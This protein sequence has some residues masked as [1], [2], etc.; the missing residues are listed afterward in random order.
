MVAKRL[1]V[2]L[3]F[4]AAA[5]EQQ[6]AAEASEDQSRTAKSRR[7]SSYE[8]GFRGSKDWA[9]SMPLGAGASQTAPQNKFKY[10]WAQRLQN[11]LNYA[12]SHMNFWWR[13]VQ[14]EKMQ[15]QAYLDG[16][17]R[18]KELKLP[19]FKN[20]HGVVVGHIDPEPDLDRLHIKVYTP[21]GHVAQYI[22]FLDSKDGDT[23]GK[24]KQKIKDHPEVTN[25][26]FEDTR[27][28]YNG[29][30]LVDA[31]TLYEKNIHDD[32]ILHAADKVHDPMVVS[33]F[34][35]QLTQWRLLPSTR[36]HRLEH[37]R[38]IRRG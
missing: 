28:F 18:V 36:A 6:P 15:L 13:V 22:C 17:R 7:T 12:E 19:E 31:D 3:L 38:V 14:R 1:L 33:A 35:A 11:T 23:I 27:V 20:K 16:E 34:S 8:D 24:I 2:E 5:A 4:A 37:P 25:M 10:N 32:C 21:Q 26:T 30:E 9:S 29:R